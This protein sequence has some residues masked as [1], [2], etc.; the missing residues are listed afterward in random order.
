MCDGKKLVRA[1]YQKFKTITPQGFWPDL[2]GKN[3]CG[4]MVVISYTNSSIK[5]IKTCENLMF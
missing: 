4:V 3:P 2:R 5:P 1:G